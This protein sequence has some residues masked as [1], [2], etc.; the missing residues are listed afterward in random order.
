VKK[1]TLTVIAAAAALVATQASAWSTHGSHG[2]H[3]SYGYGHPGYINIGTLVPG[4]TYGHGGYGGYGN[5]GSTY[6]SSYGSS[7]IRP[8]SYGS[9]VT[10]VS[11]PYTLPNYT[12][13]Y[14]YAQP[15]PARVISTV[16]YSRY[17]G[18]YRRGCNC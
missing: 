18:G 17:Y 9:R 12:Y 15:A 4:T 6:G 8:A 14:G 5:Y 3:G 2:Y 7:Y 1:F 10:H 16:P 11:Q 13:S